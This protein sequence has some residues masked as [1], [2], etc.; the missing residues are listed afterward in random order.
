M[1]Y[2][3][4]Y[5]FVIRIIWDLVDLN[6]KGFFSAPLV[7]LWL[8]VCVQWVKW[9]RFT[10][11]GRDTSELVVLSVALEGFTDADKSDWVGSLIEG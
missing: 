1:P 3:P 4:L 10:Y 11:V 9:S 5:T 8:C 2:L 7:Y 6:W